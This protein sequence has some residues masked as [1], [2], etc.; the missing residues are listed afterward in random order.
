VAVE[1]V[2]PVTALATMVVLVEVVLHLLQPIGQQAVVEVVLVEQVVM[3]L[4]G[5]LLRA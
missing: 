2:V 3:Q 4:Q 5:L 1:V